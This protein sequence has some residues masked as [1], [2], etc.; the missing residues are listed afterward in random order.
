MTELHVRWGAVM[1]WLLGDM[2]R[3][4]TVCGDMLLA[5]ARGMLQHV[6]IP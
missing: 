5:T 4:A 3:Y 1:R 2:M 6:M